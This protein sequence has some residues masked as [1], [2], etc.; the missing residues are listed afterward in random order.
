MKRNQY[1]LLYLVF[2]SVLFSC[3][4]PETTKP[5]FNLQPADSIAEEEYKIYSIAI[6]SIYPNQ[7]FILDQQSTNNYVVNFEGS[8]AYELLT[9]NNTDID[10]SLID[11]F[12]FQNDT[13]YFFDNA[14]YCLRNEIK[15]VSHAKIVSIFTAEEPA[16]PWDLFYTEYPGSEGLVKLSR[17]GFNLNHDQA[18]FEIFCQIGGTSGTGFL[19]YLAKESNNWIFR[20]IILFWIS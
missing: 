14:F 6:D 2:F 16:D 4:E 18:L 7:A 15:L 10:S 19:V 8:Y 17:I 20:D 5:L 12:I 11:N 13:F 9:A 3:K 1:T